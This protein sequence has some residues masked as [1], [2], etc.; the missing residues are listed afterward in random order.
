MKKV[1]LSLLKARAKA[2][3]ERANGRRSRKENIRV[4]RL[5]PMNRAGKVKKSEF[6]SKCNGKYTGK[7][8]RKS[9]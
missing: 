7:I 6:A 9:V 4:G 5:T 2:P 8:D 3:A 1:L